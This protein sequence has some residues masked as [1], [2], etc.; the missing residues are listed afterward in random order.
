MSL[1]NPVTPPGN[2][3]GTVRLVAQRLNHHTI[4]NGRH[5]YEKY[6]SVQDVMMITELMKGKK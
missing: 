2:N 3:P 1:K 5:V 6:Y 4:L